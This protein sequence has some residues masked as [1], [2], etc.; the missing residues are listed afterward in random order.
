[1]DDDTDD[2]HDA[3]RAGDDGEIG[4]V[5]VVLLLVG[6]SLVIAGLT[7]LVEGWVLLVGIITFVAGAAVPLGSFR[8]RRREGTATPGR[9]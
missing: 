6:T 4:P 8:R 2:A 7:A 3:G 1:V 9:R 5:A